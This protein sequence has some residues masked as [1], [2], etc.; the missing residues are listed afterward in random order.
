MP[1]YQECT[2][3]VDKA[4]PE[5]L[6]ALCQR[7]WA[8]GGFIR[9]DQNT[10]SVTIIGH[11]HVIAAAE[12]ICQEFSYRDGY[13]DVVPPDDTETVIDRDEG[14]KD[15]LPPNEPEGSTA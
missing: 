5:T 6:Q 13:R 15:L 14:S 8:V 4:T 7:I 11:P 2:Y 12:S 9:D 3:T 1:H 10:R